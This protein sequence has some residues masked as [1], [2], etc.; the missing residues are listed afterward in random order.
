MKLSDYLTFI[1]ITLCLSVVFLVPGEGDK[2]SIAQVRADVVRLVEAVTGFVTDRPDPMLLAEAPAAYAYDTQQRP[3]QVQQNSK[4]SSRR[5]WENRPETREYSN[6]PSVRL[7][8]GDSQRG[9]TR[10]TAR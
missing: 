7:S 6:G 3:P 1:P 2:G 8:Y 5:I 9:D 4:D 10:H